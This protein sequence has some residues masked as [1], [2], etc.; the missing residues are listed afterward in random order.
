MA[1]EYIVPEIWASTPEMTAIRQQIHQHPELG[2]EE[3]LTSDLVAEKLTQWGYTVHR[4]L[5]GTGVVGQLL[6][7]AGPR[8]GLRADMDALPI[9]EATGL[10]YASVH[11]GQMHACGHDGHTASLL[12]AAKYL[13]EHKLFSGTLN[14]IFQPAEEGMGGAKKMMDDGLFALF[15]CDAIFGYHNMPGFPEGHFGFRA[16]PM[17]ASSDNVAI[18]IQGQG[19]HGAMPHLSIDPV[20][21]AA[22]IVMAL[23][24]IVARNVNPLDTAVITVGSIQAGKTNNVVPDHADMKLSVRALNPE[25]RTLL[26]ERIKTVVQQQAASFGA[27]AVIDYDHTYPVLVNDVACTDLAREVAVAHFGAEALIPDLQPLT[28][29]EDFAFYLEACPGAYL[30]IGNGREGTHGCS[31]HNPGYDFNDALLPIA[32]TYWVRL[33]ERFL[34]VA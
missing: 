31:V 6:N 24:S 9:T 28:G 34:P 33:V 29:S 10:P 14:L 32:A 17:M 27:S 12:A 11:E 25:V 4:G 18:R 16:G 15:P 22:S 1:K 30:L 8:L 21:V 19:G 2:Y 26:E 7:G 3:F 23:Q 20:V 13:A 5:G